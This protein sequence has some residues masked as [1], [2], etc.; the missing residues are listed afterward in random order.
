MGGWMSY[1]RARNRN[2]LGWRPESVDGQPYPPPAVVDAHRDPN[3]YLIVGDLNRMETGY[4]APEVEGAGCGA[5]LEDSPLHQTA[6]ETGVDVETV[7][8]V[9]AFVFRDQL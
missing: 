5:R 9:L 6:R 3:W 2:G 1:R 7:R 8:R 4:L